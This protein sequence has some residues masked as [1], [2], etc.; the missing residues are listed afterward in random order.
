[1]DIAS[2]PFP[3]L[4]APPADEGDP[5]QTWWARPRT[6]TEWVQELALMANDISGATMNAAAVANSDGATMNAAAVANSDGAT[7]MNADIIVPAAFDATDRL[8][9]LVAPTSEFFLESTRL[10]YDNQRCRWVALK[11]FNKWRW[12][13]WRRR[14]QCGVDLIMNEPVQNRDAILL[15]DTRNKAVYCFHRRDLFTNLMTKITAA[16][17]MLPTPRP[18]TNPW[19]NQP[20]TPAQTI[21]VCQAILYDSA[22]RG[23]CPPTLFAAFCAARYDLRRFESD[24]ASLL[25]QYAI[26]SY[27]AD[28]HEHNRDTVVD[29]VLELLRDS[30]VSYS[31]IAFRRWVRATPMT[32][33]HREWLALVR[34]YTLHMNLHIEPRR[35]WYSD[36]GIYADVRS[37]YRR[38]P[39]GEAAGPRLRL[40]RRDGFTIQVG[41]TGATAE[42]AAALATPSPISMAVLHLAGLVAPTAPP[43]PDVSGNTA[44]A[45]ESEAISALLMLLQGTNMHEYE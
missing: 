4:F 1:M 5:L 16:E 23:R 10:F 18:P 19:T 38:T 33:I 31:A 24:N 32:P 2:R 45:A 9:S 36:A 6:L 34:D 15:T 29:T 3:I 28:I 21:A 14:P 41:G 43:T 20:L 30:G 8:S 22:I 42:S 12:N 13:V 44:D 25:A 40:L 7:T 11:A 39:V 35:H 26:N 27:F 37:L 17:E